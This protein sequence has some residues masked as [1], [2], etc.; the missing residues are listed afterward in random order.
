VVVLVTLRHVPESTDPSAPRGVDLPGAALCAVGLG[1]LTYGLT[2]W[3]GRG[4]GDPVVLAT[5]VCGVVALVGFVVVEAHSAHPALPLSLLAVPTFRAVNAVTFLVYAALGGVFFLL[6]VA[7]QVV[8]GFSPLGSGMALLP[9]TALMLL[10]SARAGV[11]A[12]RIGPRIPMTVGL[13]VATGGL[14]LLTRIGPGAAYLADVLPAVV[15]FGL[16][17]SLTV[18]PLT[19]VALSSAGDEHAGVASGVNNAVARTAGLLAVAVLPLV[20]GVGSSLTD[21]TT[22]APAFRTAMFVCAGLMAVG[23][24]V[25]GLRIPG[26][27]PAGGPPGPGAAFEAPRRHCAVDAPPLAVARA[28]GP[29]VRPSGRRSRG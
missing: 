8:A 2:A 22:L 1:G 28:D 19:A 14:L 20:A 27:E 4:G 11:L 29:P 15:V 24:L 16:G 21:A 10:L 23:A 17:L 3:S 5:L 25:A 6:G 7:L 13:L 18:A 26:R 12:G 9:V